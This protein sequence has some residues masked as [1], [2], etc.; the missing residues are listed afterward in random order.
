MKGPAVN[1]RFLNAQPGL[2]V[3]NLDSAVAYYEQLG[4]RSVYRNADM[5]QVMQKDSVVIHLSTEDVGAG[6]GQIM[7]DNVGELYKLAI[8]LGLKI[9]YDGLG[10]RPWGCRDFSVEDPDGN[11]ITF[12]QQL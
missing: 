2:G 8:E 6:G 10:D 9:L 5:H 4:F 3:S 12:S 1:V 11:G 7:V